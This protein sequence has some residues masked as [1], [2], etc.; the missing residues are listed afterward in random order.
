M[1][2]GLAGNRCIRL[3][4]AL[5]RPVTHSLVPRPNPNAV[6]AR[7]SR[8]VVVS[9]VVV[10]VIGLQAGAALA[11]NLLPDRWYPGND[12]NVSFSHVLLEPLTH[13]A[14]HSA[15]DTDVEPT[16]L[17]T[18]LYHD[19]TNKEV[20][21]YD[22]NYND[23]RYGWY[24]CHGW[25]TDSHSSPHRHCNDGH[26]HIDLVNPPG[27]VWDQAEMNSLVCEEVG[28]AVN[29]AHSSDANSCMSQ[30]FALQ[31]WSGHDDITVNGYYP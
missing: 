4:V 13:V 7:Y 11:A 26:V 27:G 30:S 25:T 12:V 3:E 21:I 28:H 29:L 20:E 18:T 10:F 1:S 9:L 6:G 24:E 5:L 31:D 15:D 22:S 14:A 17:S 19:Q 8:L 23:P 2:D 16:E